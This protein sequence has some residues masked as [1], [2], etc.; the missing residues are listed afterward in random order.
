MQRATVIRLEQI[1]ASS[2]EWRS[3][4]CLWKWARL[5]TGAEEES[6]E[7]VKKTLAPNV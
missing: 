5:R 3:K 1:F 2:E 6:P 7:P 4:E